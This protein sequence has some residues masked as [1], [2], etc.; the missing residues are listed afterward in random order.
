MKYFPSLIA[1]IFLVLS[2]CSSTTA[3]DI[4]ETRVLSLNESIL[5]GD[6]KANPA[7]PYLNVAPDGTI[8]LSW[9]E[10]STVSYTNLTLPTKA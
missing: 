7:D 9:T 2:G 5:V 8:F 6:L 10:D 1:S 4:L 3:D